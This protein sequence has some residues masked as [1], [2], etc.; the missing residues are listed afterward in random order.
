MLIFF[1]SL[2]VGVLSIVLIIRTTFIFMDT[3]A[4]ENHKTQENLQDL[5]QKNIK[6]QNENKL[7][8]LKINQLK[9][10]LEQKDDAQGN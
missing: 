4:T 7:L 9:E 8:Q 1:L 3:I 10:N 6:L 5:T 2:I